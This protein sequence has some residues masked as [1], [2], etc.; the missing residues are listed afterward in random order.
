MPSEQISEFVTR[1]E[2]LMHILDQCGFTSGHG[3][4]TKFHRFLVQSLPDIFQDLSY[5]TVKGWF[6]NHAPVPEKKVLL[7]CQALKE[8]SELTFNSRE[9]MSWWLNGGHYPFLSS[10][11]PENTDV[12]RVFHAEDHDIVITGVAEI[13]KKNGM[14]QVGYATSVKETL[15]NCFQNNPD[16][17]IVD[18]NMNEEG[19]GFVLIQNIL[20]RYPHAKILVFSFRTNANIIL[21]AYQYG[22]LGYVTKGSDNEELINAVRTIVKG[23][24]YYM[25]HFAET[26]LE[27]GLI[28]KKEVDPATALTQEELNIF[29]EVSK[30]VSNETIAEDIGRDLEFVNDVINRI[31]DRL[32]VNL[33]AF[34]WL[35][36]KYNLLK[37]D[38]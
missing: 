15:E 27:S 7:V 13:L 20:D 37:L 30:G 35:A 12:I 32:G 9:V 19:D 26:I 28:P 25:P 16:I 6:Q 11:P 10:S 34:E 36:R 31:C 2:R 33:A 18:L 3:R 1:S 14:A 24:K 23:E 4:I 22:A 8:S 17:L 38:L 29:I 5:S 21:S